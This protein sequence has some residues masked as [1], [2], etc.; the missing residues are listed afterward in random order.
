MAI[1]LNSV[2][3]ALT[4][5]I[6]GDKQYLLMSQEE[7][8]SLIKKATTPPPAPV[9]IPPKPQ[10]APV[11]TTPQEPRKYKEIKF[12]EVDLFDTEN[13]HEPHNI[14]IYYIPVGDGLYRA[15]QDRRIFL[16]HCCY[17]LYKAGLVEKDTFYG[18]Q[19]KYL[20]E[21][22]FHLFD[23]CLAIKAKQTDI[24]RMF[25]YTANADIPIY[26]RNKWVIGFAPTC[27]WHPIHIKEV[28][29]QGLREE[30]S[31]ED[32]RKIL[33]E[34]DARKEEKKVKPEPPKTEEPH[35]MP[36]NVFP[37]I[38]SK[39]KLQVMRF[40]GETID[41]DL[42]DTHNVLICY[43][44]ERG[45]RGLG[46]AVL[47]MDAITR[48]L[49]EDTAVR[50]NMPLKSSKEVA[51]FFHSYKIP[52]KAFFE[53]IG[54]KWYTNLALSKELCDNLNN[55]FGFEFVL[56]TAKK[57]YTRGSKTSDQSNDES[58]IDTPKEDTKP[59]EPKKEPEPE[60]VRT[61]RRL[62][63]CERK[64]GITTVRKL[65]SVLEP[66]LERQQIIDL[67]KVTE[68]ELDHPCELTMGTA[69]R[70]NKFCNKSVCYGKA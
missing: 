70:V 10:P 28:K 35:E 67:F 21:H 24:T 58:S 25:N 48:W 44:R 12:G 55:R 11:P 54:I 17:A 66:E 61:A 30:K 8:D 27:P 18:D 64:Y 41:W 60:Y 32:L 50:A 15:T 57:N 6:K 5:L 22:G 29:A 49:K 68:Y 33:D 45:A 62:L 31:A 19:V 40:A 3:T 65:F 59:K 63:W 7:Y 52:V 38:G 34:E 42:P 51:D 56:N 39:Y 4:S 69:A 20:T 46:K 26:I 23:I 53:G 36:E 13:D 43:F 9:P 14:P 1:H 2:I 47:N 37:L 16:F